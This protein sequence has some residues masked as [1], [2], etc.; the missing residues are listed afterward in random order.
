MD[1]KMVKKVIATS[2]YIFSILGTISS[3]LLL[4]KQFWEWI[5]ELEGEKSARQGR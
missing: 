1:E 2:L 4:T 3:L 5:G